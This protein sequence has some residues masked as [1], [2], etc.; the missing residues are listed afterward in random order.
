MQHGNRVVEDM[1]DGLQRYMQRHNVSR[2]KD[3]VGIANKTLVDPSQLDTLTEVVS[4]I[5]QDKCIG[6]GLCE[7]SCRDGAAYAISMKPAASKCS[8][9]NV[10]NRV[11]EV[12]RNSCVGCKL[13]QF[14]CPV[15]AISFETRLRIDRPRW[16]KEV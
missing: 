11:A 4:V 12:D 14:V 5:D 10:N 16:A 8:K 15:G 7:I 2:V 9:T 1:T 13:C 3:L 6:C